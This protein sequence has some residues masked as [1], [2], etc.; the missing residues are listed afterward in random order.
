M[1]VGNWQFNIGS[2]KPCVV[3]NLV[4][5][6][7]LVLSRIL[8][9]VWKDASAILNAHFHS[10]SKWINPFLGAR[11][12]VHSDAGNFL[13]RMFFTRRSTGFVKGRQMHTVIVSFC[14][15]GCL[16]MDGDQ[17]AS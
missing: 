14:L 12:Q 4:L 16:Y 1:A 17:Q 13:V 9:D 7:I 3:Q 15:A 2:L 5:H 10:M 6:S 8:A 11:T